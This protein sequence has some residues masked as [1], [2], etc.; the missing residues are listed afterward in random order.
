M[1]FLVTGATGFLGQHLVRYL[2]ERRHETILLVREVFGMGQPLPTALQAMRQELDLVY[3]DLRNLTLTRRALAE[4]QPDIVIHLAAAGV[5][6]PFISIDTALRHN[7]TGTSNLVLATFE[8]F[9]STKRLVVARTPGESWPSNAYQAS[10]A[11]A[12]SFC[13]MYARQMAWSINGA[14][15]FQAYGPGQPS[16]TLVPA[17]F[18]AALEGHDFPMTSGEQQRDWIYVDDVVSGLSTLAQTEVESGISIDLG[19]GKGTSLL[20]VVQQIYSLVGRGGQPLPGALGN[21]P[22]EEPWQVANAT[23]T[24]SLVEWK[25]T[26]SLIDGLRRML[27]T[28]QAE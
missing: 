11:A 23:A 10:K 13:Q 22:G 20:E 14:T 6:E 26:I 1:R 7:V 12:W 5:T 21:R 15:I 24:G 9:P 17:A 19:T 27:V 8:Q 28:L 4:A 16:N 2:R 25:S 3:A 18:E